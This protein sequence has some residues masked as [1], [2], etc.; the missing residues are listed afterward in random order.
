[1]HAHLFKLTHIKQIPFQIRSKIKDTYYLGYVVL[2]NN[3]T[4]NADSF[5]FLCSSPSAFTSSYRLVPF[6]VPRWLW[7]SQKSHVNLTIRNP[8]K[9]EDV[10]LLLPQQSSQ[11]VFFI[12]G[13]TNKNS[14]TY[15][16]PNHNWQRELRL[17][18]LNVW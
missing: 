4:K 14:I 6:V 17:A 2:I 12:S 1:M 16:Y 8:R 7:H 5:S 18:L 9:E 15:P 11:A 3:F 10:H 13:L